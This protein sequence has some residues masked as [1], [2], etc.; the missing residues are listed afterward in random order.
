MEWHYF[1]DP[2]H[3]R[4]RDWAALALMALFFLSICGNERIFQ[5]MQFTFGLCGPLDLEASEA[6]LTDKA[7]NGG[8][9]LGRYSLGLVHLEASEAVL[10]DKA[11]N[12]GFMLGRYSLGLVHFVAS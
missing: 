4:P 12:G 3:T 8:F 5:S 9:M 2:R 10:T 6:V 11:Y 7:Y 1:F